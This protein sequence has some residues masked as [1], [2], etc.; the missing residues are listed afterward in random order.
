MNLADLTNEVNVNEKANRIAYEYLTERVE[1][2]E[3]L[4]KTKMNKEFDKISSQL[5]KIEQ[6]INER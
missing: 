3:T 4:L 2:L 5:S 6:S 1:L